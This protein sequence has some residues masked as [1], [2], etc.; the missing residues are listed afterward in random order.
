MSGES[1]PDRMA[2]FFFMGNRLLLIIDV[3]NYFFEQNSKAY[4]KGSNLMIRKIN[5][6]IKFFEK[7]NE[8]II[9]VKFVPSKRKNN[10]DKWWKHLPQGKDCELYKN[11]YLPKK[12]HIFKKDTYS[13]FKKR[14]FRKLLKT[15]EVEKIYFAGVM[16]ELCV[17]SNIR[18]S[19]EFGYENYLFED[20]VRSR[21]VKYHKYS[22]EIIKRGFAKIINSK[23]FIH[24]E[25]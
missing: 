20:L 7:N 1:H 24:G 15:L 14:S 12:F 22:I 21:N 23:D 4:I 11:L 3:Q 18:E 9:F 2:L 17:E 19:F 13:I 8:P 16:T 25:L 6:T 5:R 10:F